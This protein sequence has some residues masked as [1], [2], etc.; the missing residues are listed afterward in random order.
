MPA[1]DS[2]GRLKRPMA[3][4]CP[5]WVSAVNQTVTA[6]LHSCPASEVR[7]T[8]QHP[9]TRTSEA[10]GHEQ[11]LDPGAAFDLKFLFEFAA[12]AVGTSNRRHQCPASEVRNTLQHPLTRT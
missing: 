5:K 8:L 9:L 12:G 1:T 3:P 7:N 6:R 11:L 4:P 10:K 2:N